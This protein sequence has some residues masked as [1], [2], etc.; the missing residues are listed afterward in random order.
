M[1]FTRLAQ[2]IVSKFV[3]S[4]Q[5]DRFSYIWKAKIENKCKFFSWLMVLKKILTLDKLQLRGW[6]SNTICSLCGIE[7]RT[8]VHLFMEC[9]YERQV[10]SSIWQK[11]G[12]LMPSMSPFNGDM[13][14]WWSV[15]EA[16]EQRRCFDGLSS[17]QHGEFSFK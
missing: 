17:T 10:W 7:P 4:L 8:S 6:D 1:G 2:F 11:L 5:D 3:G 14:E 15:Q 13:L 9:S 16:N 12:L